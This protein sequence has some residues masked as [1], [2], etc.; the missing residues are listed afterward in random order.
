MTS[1]ND[2]KAARET[3]SAFTGMVKWSAVAIAV[4]VVL[5]VALISG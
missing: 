5:V 1:G 3:Y 2:I 4:I